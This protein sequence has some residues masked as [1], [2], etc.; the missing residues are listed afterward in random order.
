MD[1]RFNSELNG[2]FAVHQKDL[3]KLHDLLE[4]RIGQVE[5]SLDCSDGVHRTPKSWADFKSYENSESKEIVDLSIRSRSSNYGKSV[6][7]DFSRDRVHPIHVN[8]ACPDEE[9]LNLKEDIFD[10]LEGMQH[11]IVSNIFNFNYFK[12]IVL[13]A[14][15]IG[16]IILIITLL[17]GNNTRDS[18]EPSISYVQA[19]Y[20]LLYI[21]VWGA[22]LIFAFD[23]LRAKYLPAVYFAL[24]QG[25]KRYENW[26]SRWIFAMGGIGVSVGIIATI[27]VVII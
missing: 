22:I 20:A 15:I 10:I 12:C 8:I 25:A 4:S 17:F 9:F 18:S 7:I 19:F 3:D 24:G 27:G 11:K 6:Q 13:P 1:A 23:K 16:T 5:V 21:C 14:L 2:A 26:K